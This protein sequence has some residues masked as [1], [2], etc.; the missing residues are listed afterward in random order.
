M[1]IISTFPIVNGG[2]GGNANTDLG[3]T[4]LVDVVEGEAPELSPAVQVAIDG[5]QTNLTNLET[6]VN[7][8]LTTLGAE[9]EAAK[10]SVSDGK[11]LVANAITGKGIATAT[12][13]TFATMASNISSIDTLTTGTADAT[14]TAA[15][16]LSGQTAYVKGA[17]VTGSMANNGAVTPSA[18][19]AGGSYTIPAGYHN[20]SGK[21]T[22]NSLASQTSAT[23]TAATIL[24]GYTAWV[25]GNKITGT[26]ANVNAASGT[27]SFSLTGKN[28]VTNSYY[29]VT[30]YY[31]TGLASTITVGFKPSILL[32]QMTGG[33]YS[34]WTLSADGPTNWQHVS[35]NGVKYTNFTQATSDVQFAPSGSSQAASLRLAVTFTSTGVQLT[36]T[37]FGGSNTYHIEGGENGYGSTATTA[38]M[39]F[40]WT[41]M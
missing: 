27:G 23:A 19:N 30:W 18:L 10:K 13:A 8:S 31:Y 25:N 11:I 9:V 4:E 22:A 26:K 6:E 40:N 15:Q 39:T 14:A 35:F 32:L 5:I 1:P 24:S 41:L 7:E 3:Y 12:D 28:S 21:V 36:A 37:P 2:G 29:G 17:K 16:I 34:C 38:N 20:G 33:L